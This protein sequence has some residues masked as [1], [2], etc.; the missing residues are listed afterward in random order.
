MAT[1]QADEGGAGAATAELNLLDR[2]VQEGK[3]AVEPSQSTYAKKLLGQFATQ[4]LDEGMRAAPDKGVVAMI[5]ERIADIDKILSD[6]LNAIMHNEQ[7]QALEGSWR[8]MRDMVFG[9]ETGPQLKLRLLNVS[10][11]ELL[12]DLESAVDHDMSVL[13][14]KVYEEEYGTFGGNPY[15]MLIGDYYFGRHHLLLGALLYVADPE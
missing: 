7:F 3:M 14:K 9:T 11:K 10:K 13:F 6:Q 12:K 1:K 2:I 15:S 4:I 5:N 8:G